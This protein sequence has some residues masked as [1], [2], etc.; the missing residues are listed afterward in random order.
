MGVLY[1]NL[2]FPFSLFIIHCM[3]FLKLYKLTKLYDVIHVREKYISPPILQILKH[4]KNVPISSHQ[5][6]LNPSLF[7]EST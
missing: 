5:E 3:Q 1:I 7:C 6:F 4:F 2:L